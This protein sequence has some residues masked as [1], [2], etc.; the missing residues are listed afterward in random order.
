MCFGCVCTCAVST[1]PFPFSL[2]TIEYLSYI[3]MEEHRLGTTEKQAPMLPEL[4]RQTH[5]LGQF[6]PICFVFKTESVSVKH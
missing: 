2:A 4:T 1:S 6:E 5:L 3:D